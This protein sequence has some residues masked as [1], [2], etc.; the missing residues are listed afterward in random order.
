MKTQ[1]TNCEALSDSIA[2]S[3]AR[4]DQALSA[5][6]TRGTDHKEKKSLNDLID[7]HNSQVCA[8]QEQEIAQ[9]MD[10]YERYADESSESDAA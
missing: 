5:W 7:A 1:Y 3:T 10:S 8:I 4:F 2:E 6:T 9:W